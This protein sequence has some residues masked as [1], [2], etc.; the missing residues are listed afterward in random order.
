MNSVQEHVLSLLRDESPLAAVAG[1]NALEDFVWQQ[2]IRAAETLGVAPLLLGH[3]DKLGLNL[4]DEIRRHLNR[5]L[6]AHTARN[7]RLLHEFSLLA[8]ALN[9]RG[10]AFM[11]VKGVHL[12][13]SLYENIGERAIW[14]IDLLVQLEQMREALEV[15]EFHRLSLLPA[16]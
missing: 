15:V 6:Q 2:V 7:L 16:L 14:D 13:T 5:I 9:G 11:P 10:I 12:C 4:S 8:R 3:A 1:L